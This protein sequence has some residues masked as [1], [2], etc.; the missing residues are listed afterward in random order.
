MK[1]ETTVGMDENLEAALSYLL[2]FLTGIY[3]LVSEKKNEYVKW[4]AAQS[5]VFSIG[6]IVIS[7]IIGVI[8]AIGWMISTLLN[9]VFLIIWLFLMY[10][11]YSG[12]KYKLPIIDKLVEDVYQKSKPKN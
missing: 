10:K 12:E 5:T 4:H 9:I 3:F 1:G 6:V 11:A 8:P 2:G 7:L